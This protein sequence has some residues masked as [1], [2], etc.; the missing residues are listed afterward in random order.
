MFLERW[1]KDFLKERLEKGEMYIY[2]VELKPKKAGGGGAVTKIPKYQILGVGGAVVNS[3][4]EKLLDYSDQPPLLPPKREGLILIF[5]SNQG[6][7]LY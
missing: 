7:S 2:K 5:F 3:D 1:N 6:W 4:E